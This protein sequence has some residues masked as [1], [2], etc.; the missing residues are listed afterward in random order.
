MEFVSVVR[1]QDSII[2]E[3]TLKGSLCTEIFRNQKTGVISCRFRTVVKEP[4]HLESDYLKLMK[5]P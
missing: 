4:I 5:S 1:L 2:S 3:G